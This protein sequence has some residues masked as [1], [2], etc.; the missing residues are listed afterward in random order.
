VVSTECTQPPPEQV[1]S[2]IIRQLQKA[3]EFST[4]QKLQ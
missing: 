4:T 3:D 1:K 2:A